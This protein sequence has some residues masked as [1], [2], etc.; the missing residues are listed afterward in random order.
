MVDIITVIYRPEIYYLEIQARSIE[1]Y[2]D[3]DFINNIIIVVNDS[4]DVANLIDTNWY[5]KNQPKVKIIPY[6]SYGYDFTK[7][8][9]GWDNQQ[10]C[11]IL[12][13]HY[14]S[15]EWSIVL[16]AKTYFVRPC[17]KE[18]FFDSSNKALT[19]LQKPMGSFESA[20]RFVENFFNISLSR[21]VGPGGVPFIFHNPTVKDMIEDCEKISG[22]SFIDFFLDNV[23]FPNH[24]TEFVL[25]SGYI[26]Y[27]Y[28][29][30][31]HLYSERRMWECVN[32]A[33]WE[34]DRYEELLVSMHIY[35]TI[36]VSVQGKAWKLLSPSQQLSYLDF[37][38]SKKLVLEPKNT[39]IKLNTVIN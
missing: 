3:S 31:N 25:Y 7:R 6:S 24:I 23:L 9:S 33:D 16:D 21:I 29:N 20:E 39:Q 2:L 15:Q 38:N 17:N 37:L 11:K 28:N 4:D 13:S 34:I 8:V 10:L 5:G 26:Q 12:A 14:S 1:E 32:V 30:F 22:L 19:G 18:T 35:K 36:T 27:K